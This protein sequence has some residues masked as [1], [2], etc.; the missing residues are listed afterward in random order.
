MIR[1]FNKKIMLSFVFLLSLSLL[2]CNTKDKSITLSTN[3][4][5]DMKATENSI[6]E[7]INLGSSCLKS[8][9]FTDARSYFE[10]AISYDK[11]KSQ[12]YLDIKDKYLEVNRLDDAYYFI[13]L[14]VDN[15]VDVDNTKKILKD[16]ESKFETSVI[17]DTT[18]V[19]SVYTPPSEISIKVNNELT[20]VKVTWNISNISTDKSGNFSYDGFLEEY[21]RKV[22]LNLTV[23]KIEKERKIGFI[24]DL[25]EKNGEIFIKLDEC[26]IF[27][28]NLKS[29]IA[30]EEA[31]KDGLDLYKTYGSNG[32][33]YNGYYIRNKTI[34]S[35]EYKVSKNASYKL[36]DFLLNPSLNSVQTQSI[37]YNT[38][39]DYIK[40]K[41]NLSNS[42]RDLL[43]WIN[44]ED[45]I[46]INFEMQYTP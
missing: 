5:E 41:L 2:G 6:L 25:Y 42:N 4:Q 16:I 22:K 19:N 17:N 33:I 18:P 28:D 13:K 9:N 24:T 14:A 10:K 35:I 31:Q 1:Y 39:K 36:D 12:T 8:Q 23:K 29:N 15:N 26:Q 3:V 43:F 37:D 34:E 46:I 32:E 38:F 21:G 11:T 40:S 27:F 30:S 20:K 7:N 44:T 45:N